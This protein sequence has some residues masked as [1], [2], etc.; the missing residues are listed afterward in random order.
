MKRLCF[1]CALAAI[2]GPVLMA[3]L[4][5]AALVYGPDLPEGAW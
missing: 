4:F 3:G 1:W 2:L 5:Y